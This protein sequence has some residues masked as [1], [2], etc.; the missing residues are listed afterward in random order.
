MGVS[1][2]PLLLGLVRGFCRASARTLWV[3]RLGL[4]PL[5]LA[6]LVLLL[7]GP[8][9][10]EKLAE[11]AIPEPLRPWVPWVMSEV[12]SEACTQV[13]EHHRCA[14]PSALRLELTDRG[15]KFELDYYAERKDRYRIP[16]GPTTFPWNVAVDSKLAPITKLDGFPHVEL[17]PGFHHVKGEFQWSSLPDTLDVGTDTAR[18]ELALNG[19]ELPFFRRDAGKIWLVTSAAL[20]ETQ[21]Q[22]QLELSVFR[23]VEDGAFL[24][25]ETRLVLQV[26]GRTREVAFEHP[27]LVE[28]FP[29]GISGDLAVSLEP[30]GRLRVQLV[31]GRHELTLTARAGAPTASLHRGKDSAPWPVDEVWTFRATG[32]LRAVEVG[33]VTGVDPSRTDLPEAW[34]SESAYLV[35]PDSAMTLLTTRRGEEQIR[36]NQLDLRREF[37]LDESA[38]AF[39]VVDH[40]SG[41]MNRD[42][43]LDLNSGQLGAV[44]LSGQDQLVTLAA[45]G[46]PGIE[47]REAAVQMEAVSRVERGAALEAV[48]WSSDVRSL[49]ADLHLP[50]GWD[51]FM[52]SNVDEA[53]D[54]WV[55]RWSLFDVFYALV[56]GAAMFRLGG[57]I[58]G[59]AALLA[60]VLCRDH[61][62]A[63]D[64]FWLPL[65]ALGA[66][67]RLVPAGRMLNLVR[68]LFTLLSLVLVVTL[69]SFSVSQI[70]RALYPHLESWAG[71][72]APL[73]TM[74]LGAAS[75]PEAQEGGT[76][77]SSNALSDRMAAKQEAAPVEADG[78]SSA[79]VSKR[80]LKYRA[81]A[82]VQTG[83]GV[84]HA[85]GPSWHLAWSGPVVAT[86]EM[87]LY[88]ISPGL[89]ALLTALRLASL[90]G[91]FFFVIRLSASEP[92]R[93][94]TRSRSVA[95]LCVPLLGIFGARS[96]SAEALPSNEQLAELKAR[97]VAPAACQPECVTV[98]RLVVELGDSIVFRAQVT[99]AAI[100]TYQLPGPASSFRRWTVTEDGQGA[101]ALRREADGTLFLRLEPGV[102]E[103]ELRAQLS[104][105]RATVDVGTFPE[106]VLLQGSGYAVT[107]VSEKGV[108]SGRTLTFQRE[109]ASAEPAPQQNANVPPYFLVERVLELGVTSTVTTQVRR[110]SEATS[111]EVLRLNLLPFERVITPGLESREG[112]VELSFPRE[113]TIQSFESNLVLSGNDDA[114]TLTLSAPALDFETDIWTVRC[115]VVFSCSFDGLVPTSHIEDG[116]SVLKFHPWPGEKLTLNVKTTRAAPGD[117]ITVRSALLRLIPGLRTARGELE[118]EFQTSRSL[119]HTLSIPA[120][121]TLERANVDG[122][123][124][125]VK[126]EQGRLRL[127]LEPGVRKV[128][129]HWVD[130]SQLTTVFS[131]PS[132]NLGARGVN[133]QTVIELPTDRWVLALGGPRQGPAL[134]F[135]GYLILILGL[136]FVLPRL[137]HCPLSTRSWALLGLGL[138]QVPVAAAVFIGGWFFAIAGRSTWLNLRRFQRNFLQLVLV[139]YSIGFL[140]ALL[141]AVY[142]GLAS[143]PDMSIEGA[144]SYAGHLSWYVDR[145]DGGFRSSWVLSVSVWFFRIF[146]LLWALWLSA[147]LLG[148]LK[149]AWSE[150]H[151]AGFWVPKPSLARTPVAT[152]SEAPPMSTATV[153][154]E[155]AEPLERD[156]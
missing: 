104:S 46:K 118:V 26:S 7:V 32:S 73:P 107:G 101:V 130:N 65:I 61:S 121:A 139:F 90:L 151:K 18:I 10:A 30:T 155:G 4:H 20:R 85:R 110:V 47:L 71:D 97:L 77:D 50:P 41:E 122:V 36:Q 94:F 27:L 12:G 55:S 5:R 117:H 43:R 128:T 68:T 91:L 64:L 152:V 103:V 56:V 106:H 17:E 120:T 96:A 131:T 14:W 83:P 115:G 105:E 70:R 42:F 153:A 48:G 2:N 69:L 100:A 156:P 22:D 82:V 72:F 125:S 53:A 52:V 145:S 84:P 150:L 119:V 79:S 11:R 49:S 8:A 134:L 25:I 95:L 19:V 75:A 133:F 123:E 135:W 29:L 112:K 109:G 141:G 146:M 136:A 16:G 6:L 114:A 37:W 51:V 138:T 67:L 93:W 58:A 126:L 108:V 149:W 59:G 9:G 34:R 144:G 147:A 127:A 143:S 124:Q 21:E 88:L 132:V 66:L 31:P 80:Q 98:P 13:G 38:R 86:Q 87:H 140:I 148:W 76:G 142:S 102:H 62:G 89:N 63:P 3:R 23:R 1:S 40:F 113:A 35:G 92:L 28:T 33:G 24:N 44:S 39:T 81:D 15:G 60:L 74:V 99:A 54:T 129:V 45:S 137:P 154:T 57:P 111:P 78:L 116:R